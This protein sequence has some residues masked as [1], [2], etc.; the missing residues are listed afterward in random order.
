MRNAIFMRAF[1]VLA[2]V[3]AALLGADL[4]WPK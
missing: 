2:S 1:M 3:G 4:V